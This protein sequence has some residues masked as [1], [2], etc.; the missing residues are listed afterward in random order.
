MFY[1]NN[2]KPFAFVRLNIML[3]TDYFVHTENVTLPLYFG[4]HFRKV[5]R[6]KH[7][8]SQLWKVL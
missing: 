8:L 5:L 2:R 7:I 1:D 3:P 6:P 4:Q